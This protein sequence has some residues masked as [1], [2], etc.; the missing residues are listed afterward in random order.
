M[1]RIYSIGHSNRSLE[2]FVAIL[3]SY[4]IELLVD[5][6][7]FPTSKFKQFKKENLAEALNMAGIEY[8]HLEELGG[9][10][11]GYED[12]MQS[13]KWEEG[14][15][16]LKKLSSKKLAA[17]MCAE[18]FPFRCHRRWIARKLNL[19]GWEVVHILNEKVW[20]EK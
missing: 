11:G 2:E 4:K 12:Y 15:E 6:R 8:K 16:Y 3:K 14:Y 10:R 13:Q 7:R 17:F 9:Y 19:E 1:A 18:K 5:I 20:C